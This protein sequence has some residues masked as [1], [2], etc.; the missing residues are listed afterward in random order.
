M[1][2]LGLLSISTSFGFTYISIK[3]FSSKKAKFTKIDEKLK[4]VEP[5]QWVDQQVGVDQFKE[6]L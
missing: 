2:K 3:L 4:N 6:L 5:S 1:S